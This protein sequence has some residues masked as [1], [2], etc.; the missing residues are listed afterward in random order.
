M[1]L[2]KGSS[3][4]VLFEGNALKGLWF[5]NESDARNRE[6]ISWILAAEDA[7][8]NL[9]TSEEDYL[10]ATFGLCEITPAPA[11][12]GGFFL[13]FPSGTPQKQQST[14]AMKQELSKKWWQLWK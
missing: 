3:S 5:E 6:K 11:N 1:E 14:T 8:G 7:K 13:F 12:L 10:A 4:G 2:V 9:K